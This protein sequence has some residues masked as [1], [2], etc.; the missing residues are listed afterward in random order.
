M[1]PLNQGIRRDRE[2]MLP[3]SFV[4]LGKPARARRFVIDIR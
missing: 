4:M 1:P 3:V 2:R